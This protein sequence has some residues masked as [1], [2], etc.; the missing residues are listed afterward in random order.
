MVGRRRTDVNSESQ[1]KRLVFA[2]RE[3]ILNGEF[4]AGKRMTELGLVPLLRASRTPIRLALERL[5]HE[6]LLEQLPGGGF[7]VRSFAVAELLDAIELRG[8]LEG[9]AVRLAAERLE[10]P[11]EL[12]HLKGLLRQATLERPIT[13]ETFARYLEKN[14]L[15]HRELWKLAKNPPLFRA[16]EAACRIPFA[17]PGALVFTHADLDEPTALVAAQH[18]RALVEAIEGREGTRAEAL[19]RE[20]SRISRR[21]LV[22]ALQERDVVRRFPGAALITA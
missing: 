16:L 4:S 11:V 3:R 6:G 1:S 21:N 10:S 5:S 7:K 22:L 13:V 20:H 12:S 18:H 14:E 8:V 2:L 9:A 19:A 17:G 15:F